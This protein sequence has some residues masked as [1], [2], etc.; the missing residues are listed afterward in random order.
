MNQIAYNAIAAVLTYPESNYRDALAELE[1]ELPSECLEY[2]ASFRSSVGSLSLQAQQELF[3]QTFDLNPV[4]SLELGWHLFGENYERGLLLVR[5]REELRAA[6]ISE[7]G[8]LPDHLTYTL[9]LLPILERERAL[10]FAAAIVLPALMKMLKAIGGKENPYEGL[11]SA[12]ALLL[13]SDFPEIEPP[14]VK[15]ELPVLPQEVAL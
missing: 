10:D 7:C 13:R 11:L 5:M 8:E 4:C 1:L 2:V 3:T 15:V 12:T 9:R 6:G 14:E